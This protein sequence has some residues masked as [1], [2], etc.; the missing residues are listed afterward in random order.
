M[1]ADAWHYELVG[2]QM[3]MVVMERSTP[4]MVITHSPPLT[5]RPPLGC[6]LAADEGEKERWSRPGREEPGDYT[7]DR[8]MVDSLPLCTKKIK[9]I[10]RDKKKS[11]LW[12][13]LPPSFPFPPSPLWLISTP[14]CADWLDCLRNIIPLT[15][16]FEKSALSLPLIFL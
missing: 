6:R 12:A 10:R 11:K 7:K 2:S 3:G 8:K 1:K 13:F 15:S 5:S 14:A 9:H 16:R 4:W